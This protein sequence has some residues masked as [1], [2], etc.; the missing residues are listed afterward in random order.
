MT[1]IDPKVDWEGV[2]RCIAA[3]SLESPAFLTQSVLIGGGACWFYRMQLR[4]AND[5]D[6][7]EPAA[8][9]AFENLWLSKDI[10]FTGIFRGDAYE[11][12]PH[13]VVTDQS[14]NSYLQVNGIRIGFAQVGVTFD[15]EEVLS[16]ARLAQFSS[17]GSEV[18]F[19]VIDP[20]ALYR[21]KQALS[22]KRNQPNDHAHFAVLKEFLCLEFV[23]ACLEYAR[24][25]T[26]VA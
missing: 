16:R 25:H 6:F 12:L 14:G 21:E 13:L 20:I 26:S 19:L 23:N 1:P 10:D 7:Q 17:N 18:Q 11:M 3:L 15:P 2:K 22:M 5:A 9:Q 4:K 24:N 8:S